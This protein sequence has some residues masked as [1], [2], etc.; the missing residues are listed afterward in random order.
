L[1]DSAPQLE[2]L[3]LLRDPIRASGH[4]EQGIPDEQNPFANIQSSRM[5]EAHHL[6]MPPAPATLSSINFLTS[7]HQLG[8]QEPPGMDLYSSTPIIGRFAI[9]NSHEH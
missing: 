2:D 3:P 7:F 1:A 4:P 5:L 8:C 9:V 6:R